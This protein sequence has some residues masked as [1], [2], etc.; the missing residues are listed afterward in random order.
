M[1]RPQAG[2]RYIP[3]LDSEVIRESSHL[4]SQTAPDLQEHFNAYALTRGL[5]F[6]P[7]HRLQSLEHLRLCS[8]FE[9]IK[10]IGPKIADVGDVAGRERHPMRFGSRCQ[11][12]INC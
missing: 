12:R 11:Q 6:A 1:P 3:S 2:L 5:V 4:E 8:R 10:N 9:R 7:Q